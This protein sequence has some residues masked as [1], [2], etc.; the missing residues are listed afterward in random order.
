VWVE[1]ISTF[2]SKLIV[3]ASFLIPFLLLPLRLATIIAVAW[4]LLILI[5]ANIII[6]KIRT[7]NPL[8]LIGEHV[9]IA[10][11]VLIITYLVGHLLSTLF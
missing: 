8:K 2:F 1:T 5:I 10:I 3:A 6:A 11:V 4:G 9:L 7:E